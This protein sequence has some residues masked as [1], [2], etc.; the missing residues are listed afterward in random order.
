MGSFEWWEVGGMGRFLGLALS[1]R[2][3]VLFVGSLFRGGVWMERMV[4]M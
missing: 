4:W 3:R 2:S 1:V